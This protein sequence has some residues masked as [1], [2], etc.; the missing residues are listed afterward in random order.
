MGWGTAGVCPGPAIETGGSL[1][2]AA[3]Q[4]ADVSRAATGW[5]AYAVNMLLGMGAVRVLDKVI[6]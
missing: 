5:A 1:L 3:F 6:A 2:V 4:G